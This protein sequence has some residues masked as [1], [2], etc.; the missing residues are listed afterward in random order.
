MR[1]P[2]GRPCAR[3]APLSASLE[4]AAANAGDEAGHR[5]GR[6]GRIEK[7]RLGARERARSLRATAASAR[8]SLRRRSRRRSRSSA[9]ASARESEPVVG[10]ERDSV[11]PAGS[12]GSSA[13][14]RRRRLVGADADDSVSVTPASAQPATSPACVPPDDVECTMTSGGANLLEELRDGVGERRGAERRRGAEWDHVGAAGP[15]RAAPAA[16]ASISVARA[17]RVGDVADLGAEQSCQQRVRRRALGWRAVGDEHAAQAQPGGRRGGDARVIRLHAAARD[18]RVGL[19][20]EGVG[21]HQPHLADFVAAE[22][23]R[24]SCRRA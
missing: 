23:E 10:R 1:I 15:P 20:R 13:V 18:E 2:P 3:T 5:L 11:S 8:H 19:P 4:R 16:A 21:G 9:S 6:V 7:E 24:R 22:R 12:A 14:E 17:S